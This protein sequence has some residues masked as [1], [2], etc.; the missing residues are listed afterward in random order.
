MA[1]TC[2][3][4]VVGWGINDVAK[5]V[6]GWDGVLWKEVDAKILAFPLEHRLRLSRDKSFLNP[7]FLLYFLRRFEDN[8]FIQRFFG[9]YLATILFLSSNF[10]YTANFILLASIFI[11]N[12]IIFLTLVF[13][14]A[15]MIR[16]NIF[17]LPLSSFTIFSEFKYS[18]Q[19]MLLKL[20][21]LFPFVF[22]VFP[23]ISGQQYQLV[24]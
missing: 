10:T 2:E 14:G 4:W 5:W 15:I 19:Q 6:F 20:E 8:R 11:L 3:S 16:G 23:P 17:S 18:M 12:N 21:L 22:L 13:F 7:L 24:L 9:L 1:K